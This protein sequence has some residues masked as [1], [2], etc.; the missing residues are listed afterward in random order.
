MSTC[1]RRERPWPLPPR[2]VRRAGPSPAPLVTPQRGAPKHAPVARRRRLAARPTLLAG[3]ARC[4]YRFRLGAKRTDRRSQA[5]LAPGSEVT[6]SAV[7]K[8]PRQRS[9]DTA[10]AR[11][12]T[13]P[14]V[15]HP[16]VPA[17]LEAHP[18]PRRAQYLALILAAHSTAT[19]KSSAP[20]SE[21]LVR[22]TGD[23]KESPWLGEARS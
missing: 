5:P 12:R 1:H 18:L 8:R 10:R 20:R 17:I 4:W 7:P 9:S 15:A 23:C 11:R 14:S 19:P 6:P 21:L 3:A 2:S 16:R 22:M 13:S